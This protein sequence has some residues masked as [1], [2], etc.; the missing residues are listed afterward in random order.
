MKSY[1]Y[2]CGNAFKSLCKYSVGKYTGPH[3]HDFVV[4]VNSQE[5]NRV[6]VK[7]EYLA[8]FFHYFNLDFEFEIIT[9]NSDITIDDKFKKFLDDERVLKWYGQNIEISHPKINSIPI[10][11][12]N[13]KWA[14]GNQEI[15]NKIASEKIEKDNLIYVNFDVNTNYIERST[16]LEETGLSLS[17]KVDYESYLREVARSHFILSPN[18]NGI[19]CHKHWEAF[20]LNTV[21][22]VTNSMNIQHHK[23]LPF[24][25][26]KEW[27]D[28]KESDVSESKYR[29]LMKDFNNKNL[30]F[31]N[32]SKEL[33]WIK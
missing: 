5:N 26:L 11:I 29:S 12:A 31:E 8:N 27:K 25:V 17:E 13:P 9:H 3:Q 28:F 32:Y 6:F 4:N 2:I 22:V 18:G 23:H 30:L 33:G 21:P 14:H 20:Y 7:T 24:L 15:L 19:D 10:G 1:K 16:C